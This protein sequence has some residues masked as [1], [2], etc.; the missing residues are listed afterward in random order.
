[1]IIGITGNSGSGKTI[2]AKELAQ[3][4]SKKKVKLIDADKV[5]KKLSKPGNKY[6]EEIVKLFGK[7]ILL[8]NKE[9]NRNKIADIIF[10]NSSERK[11]LDDLT[12]KY[13]VGKIK[14][15]I[16]TCKSEIIIAF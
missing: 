15:D 12:Y 7:E 3:E 16:K 4:L 2:L 6:Y 8:K 14:E 10:D 1:M 9:L 13:V 5:V 11:K